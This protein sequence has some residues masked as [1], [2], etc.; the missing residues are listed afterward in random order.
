MAAARPPRR[1]RRRTRKSQAESGG[2]QGSR[3]A[4]EDSASE[5]AV[6]P[7]PGREKEPRRRALLCDASSRSNGGGGSRSRCVGP[8]ASRKVPVRS[9]G[10]GRG[11]RKAGWRLLRTRGSRAISEAMK[12]GAAAAAADD[13]AFVGAAAA[14]RVERGREG[15]GADSSSVPTTII[16]PAPSSSVPDPV[17]ARPASAQ[18]DD[19]DDEGEGTRVG[20]E[21]ETPRTARNQRVGGWAVV[22]V[23]VAVAG[24]VGLALGLTRTDRS[25]SKTSNSTSSF[26]VDEQLLAQF[27]AS[28]PAEFVAAIGNAST[29]QSRA[30][31]WLHEGEMS[32]RVVPTRER[33]PASEALT[34]RRALINVE[35]KRFIYERFWCFARSRRERRG[36]EEKKRAVLLLEVP[37]DDWG[38]TFFADG[39]RWG[40]GSVVSIIVAALFADVA[41]S[42][43]TLSA[44]DS[45]D[46]TNGGKST[47]PPWS[48]PDAP[49]EPPPGVRG[50]TATTHKTRARGGYRRNPDRTHRQGSGKGPPPRPR[51]R[52]RL[53]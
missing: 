5:R 32:L 19:D 6:L 14:P 47:G 43:R 46:I 1:R 35:S 41:P 48:P 16:L 24:A 52:R 23:L 7:H 3:S 20:A 22:L 25:G 42:S 13:G 8:H 28:L 21:P 30:Y 12:E 49:S 4:E 2:R 45:L 39:Q 11:E 17:V 53:P 37:L 10:E 34:T 33:S 38:A 31:T 27:E 36:S 26:P 9:K 18:D 50:G 40:L 51:L 15:Q 44:F 29:P